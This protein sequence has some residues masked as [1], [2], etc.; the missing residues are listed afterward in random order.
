MDAEAPADDE[1]DVSL[2]YLMEE[3]QQRCLE[4]GYGNH[5]STAGV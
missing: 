5:G 3:V 2:L 4:V 1:F